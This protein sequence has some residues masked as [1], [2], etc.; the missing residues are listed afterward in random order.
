M[1]L[2]ISTFVDSFI[3]S[4]L[5]SLVLSGLIV[6]SQ[7][8]HGRLSYDQ[9]Q[10]VQRMHTS[11]TPRI[12]G[13]AIYLT[14]LFMHLA[15]PDAMSYVLTSTLLATGF[16]VFS[17]GLVEDLTQK[18][19]VAVRMWASL[20]PA[21]F[22]YFLTNQY[23]SNLDFVGLNAILAIVPIGILFTAFA[24]SGI[25]HAINFI[26]GLNGLAAISSLWILVGL[27]SFAVSSGLQAEW[28]I[29]LMLAGAIIG[30]LVWNWPYGRL[31]L[32][33]GGAYFIGATLAWLAISISLSSPTITAW[34]MLL[35][36]AYPITETLYSIMRRVRMRL[37]SGKPDR[38]HLHQLIASVIV[39]PRLPHLSPE[40]RNSISGLLSSFMNAPAVIAA[41]ILYENPWACI[42]VFM[43]YAIAYHLLYQSLA[44]AMSAQQSEIRHHKSAGGGKSLS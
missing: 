21:L 35:L 25:T 29:S 26:D 41:L 38:A 33:D 3:P 17:F 20:L 32:G 13:L 2:A 7:K 15:D 18:V 10:G 22:A 24:V 12:G 9:T 16:I 42:A 39:Y 36:C 14:V 23:L 31:F 37:S 8:W 4:L 30:F 5:L 34:A 40:K 43:S 11:A 28:M 19:S 44:K 27:A 1:P 6:L